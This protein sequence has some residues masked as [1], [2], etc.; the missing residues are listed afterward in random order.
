MTK[1]GQLDNPRK[2]AYSFEKWDS[3]WELQ[4]MKELEADQLIDAWTK[5][6][7]I[8]IPYLD[9][10][11]HKREYRPDFL[12]RIVGGEV[13][14]HEVKGGHLIDNPNTVSKFDAA[15]RWC[16]DRDIKFEIVGK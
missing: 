7:G 16:A 11:G 9:T 8:R 13:Q 1:H 15:K 10:K 2:S 5:N 14:L 4:Y 12:V 6:H 3:S